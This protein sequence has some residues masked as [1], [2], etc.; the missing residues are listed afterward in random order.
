[1][2]DEALFLADRV[3][4]MSHRPGRIIEEIKVPFAR[5]RSAEV[6][7]TSEFGALKHRCLSLL[8]TRAESNPLPRLEPLGLDLGTS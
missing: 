3:L 5:P 7:V 4:V 8:H 6:S 2:I 1:D